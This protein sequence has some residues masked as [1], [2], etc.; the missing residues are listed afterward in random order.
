LHVKRPGLKVLFRRGY[1]EGTDDD[2]GAPPAQDAVAAAA[3]SPFAEP[4]LGVTLSTLFGHDG[5]KGNVLRS[6]V[7]VDGRDLTFAPAAGGG[8]DG[9][10]AAPPRAELELLAFA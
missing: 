10:A 1:F 3:G 6:V 2:Q 4:G 5:E 9:A 7:H 8:T